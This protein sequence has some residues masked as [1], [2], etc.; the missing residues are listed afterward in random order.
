MEP[1]KIDTT[2]VVVAIILFV[3]VVAL[4]LLLARKARGGGAAS[5][6][7]GAGGSAPR[8]PASAPSAPTGPATKERFDG[9]PAKAAEPRPAPVAPARKSEA[10]AAEPPSRPEPQ[11]PA[12]P[13]KPA[14]S[15]AKADDDVPW[16]LREEAGQATPAIEATQEPAEEPPHTLKDGL[17]KTRREGFIATL[18]GLFGRGKKVDDDVIDQ[19]EEV[20]FKADI[21]PRTVDRLLSV[22]RG[23]LSR[24][25]LNDADK[26]WGLMHDEALAILTVPGAEVTPAS[27]PRVIMMLG[28]NGTGKTTSIGKLALHFRNDGKKVLLVAGDTFRAAAAE[29]LE[30][31]GR[32]VDVP[33]FRGKEGADPASVVHD[34]VR[35]GTQDG[36]DI[37][38]VDT[39]GRLHNNTNLMEE[40]KKVRR[41]MGKAVEGAPHEV[42]LVLDATTGQNAIRQAEDFKAATDVTGLVLTKLD[43]TAKGG[44]VLGVCD[45]L[46]LPIRWIGIGERVGDLRR[47][48]PREFVDTLFEPPA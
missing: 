3:V 43:G 36:V 30:H 16:E 12:R 23:A 44:V 25:E 11:K 18:A 32:R 2:V 10:P 48:D 5:P 40:L 8:G 42:L 24:K 47:F 31:W 20:L 41:V 37:V 33:V 34:G 15:A 9:A 7:R 39:A 27:G 46:K 45:K 26:V 1:L 38:L 21:G 19:A 4:G 17:G 35:Q 13:P 29:Q 14:P 28:V 6:E 22:V